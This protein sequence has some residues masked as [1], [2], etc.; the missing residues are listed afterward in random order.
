MTH[1]RGV[2]VV[3]FTSNDVKGM[4]TLSQLKLIARH[5]HT[6]TDNCTNMCFIILVY[7]VCCCCRWLHVAPT[8]GAAALA[9]TAA[10][11]SQ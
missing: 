5:V 11:A 7:V 10:T 4:H 1:R 9:A 6:F 2:L 8:V 3:V